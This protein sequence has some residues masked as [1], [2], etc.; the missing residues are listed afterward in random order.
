MT[1]DSLTFGASG[2]TYLSYPFPPSHVYPRGFL[3]YESIAEVLPERAPP[4]LRTVKGETLFV[5]ARRRAALLEAIET[6]GLPTVRRVDVWALLLEPFLDTEFDEAH[7]ERTIALLLEHGF[8]R[9][10]IDLLRRR[11]SVPMA[12]YNIESGLWDWVHLGLFDVLMAQNGF[13]AGEHRRLSLQKFTPFYW[14]AM[15][16]AG[17]GRLLP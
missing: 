16:I 9:Q 14:E 17:R 10:A 13:I 6:Y 5:S 8:S 1:I 12:A 15:E 3:P 7:Q 2:I 4:E 11:V